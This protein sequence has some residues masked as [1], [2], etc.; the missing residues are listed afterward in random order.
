M[1]GRCKIGLFAAAVVAAIAMARPV[2]AADGSRQFVSTDPAVTQ[3]LALMEKARNGQI[4]RQEYMSAMNAEYTRLA[5]TQYA[6]A[7]VHEPAQAGVRTMSA[8]HR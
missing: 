1:V 8:P 7:N 2:M 6:T 4:S 5:G 3:T